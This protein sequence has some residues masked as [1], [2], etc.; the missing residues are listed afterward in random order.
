MHLS[1]LSPCPRRAAWR[2][3]IK[4]FLMLQDIIYVYL[5]ALFLILFH[6]EH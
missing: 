4:A 1:K 2:Y 5:A 3:L 6:V